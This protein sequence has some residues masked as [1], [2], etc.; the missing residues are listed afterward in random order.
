M[1]SDC[2]VGAMSPLGHLYNVPVYFDSALAEQERIVFNAGTHT[3][4]ISMTIEDHVRAANPIVADIA[5][6]S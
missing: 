6:R 5:R 3:D 4:A 2:D 1:F